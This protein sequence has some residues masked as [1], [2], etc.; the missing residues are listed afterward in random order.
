MNQVVNNCKGNFQ[1]DAGAPSTPTSPPGGW[2]TPKPT[3]PPT[4]GPPMTGGSK[5]SFEGSDWGCGVW[6]NTK[7][8]D[9]FDWSKKSGRTPSSNTGP[10]KASDG[11][12]YLFIETSHP[13]RSGDKAIL[14][15]K[16]AIKL[17]TSAAL[18]F[19]YHMKGRDIDTLKVFVGG[20]VV[21]EKKGQQGNNWKTET[22]SL[23]SYA[24]K[25]ATL[26]FVASRGSSWAG[27]IAIDNVIL[28][29]GGGGGPGGGATTPEPEPEPE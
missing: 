7:N 3:S 18:K 8:G 17:E 26:K 20:D 28:N 15:T 24:G 6:E 11:N 22:V 2:P 14:Q 4:T 1:K 16:S 19:D 12:Q 10:D 23:N 5:C 29:S 25:S 13:R 21:F 27:D 9:Q